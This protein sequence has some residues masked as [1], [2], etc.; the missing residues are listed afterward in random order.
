MREPTSSN[1]DCGHSTVK[2]VRSSSLTSNRRRLLD[3]GG[4]PA[5]QQQYSQSK[6]SP[7]SRITGTRPSAPNL[8]SPPRPAFDQ[9]TTDSQQG[10]KVLFLIDHATKGDALH[11]N[12]SPLLIRSTSSPSSS[13]IPKRLMSKYR[14]DRSSFQNHF[15][16]KARLIRSQL[17]SRRD[18]LDLFLMSYDDDTTDSQAR[19]LAYFD[20]KCTT[21]HLSTLY[22]RIASAVDIPRILAARSPHKKAFKKADSA[23]IRAQHGRRPVELRTPPRQAGSSRTAREGGQKGGVRS[24]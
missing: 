10:M 18:F 1:Y 5:R 23:G 24:F 21:A 20:Q 17:T 15:F 4:F 14:S 19:R 6:A 9:R 12:I 8:S 13:S 7:T 11:H 2:A 3:L 16:A 22:H